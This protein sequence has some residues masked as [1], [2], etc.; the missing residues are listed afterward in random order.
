MN[1]WL[2]PNNCK[3]KRTNKNKPSWKQHRILKAKNS[4]LYRMWSKTLYNS[5]SI[6]NLQSMY[7]KNHCLCSFQKDLV[8]SAFKM[9]WSGWSS[10]PSK[11]T[12]MSSCSL[13]N[14]KETENCSSNIR[15]D[16]IMKRESRLLKWRLLPLE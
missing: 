1:Y 10:I 12:W 6:W 2:L 14:R 8:E 9:R 13:S 16:F 7:L 4:L 11:Q 3:R 5:W 15:V